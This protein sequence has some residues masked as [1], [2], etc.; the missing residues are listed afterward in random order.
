MS[1]GGVDGE[2]GEKRKSAT[3]KNMPIFLFHLILSMEVIIFG[4]FSV[5]NCDLILL[6]RKYKQ[7]LNEDKKYK[8][9]F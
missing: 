1:F 9:S 7:C 3:E 2:S 4:I 6:C 8:F 5:A